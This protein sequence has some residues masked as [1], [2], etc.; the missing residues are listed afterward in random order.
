MS[1]DIRT[2]VQESRTVAEILRRAED[3][4]AAVPHPPFVVLNPGGSASEPRIEPFAVPVQ[5]RDGRT[6]K[7]SWAS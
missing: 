1:I 4:V 6:F 3:Y 7:E 2:R 5:V